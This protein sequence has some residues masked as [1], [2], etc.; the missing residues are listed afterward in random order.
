MI[1]KF[2]KYLESLENYSNL[3]WSLSELIEISDK[4]KDNEN[5]IIDFLSFLHSNA[6]GS[7]PNKG[8]TFKDLKIMYIKFSN[9]SNWI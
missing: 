7:N 9:N 5:K 8:W 3:D 1:Y 4:F 2:L 6:D